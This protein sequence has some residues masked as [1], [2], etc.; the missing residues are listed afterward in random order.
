MKRIYRSIGFWAFLVILISIPFGC[1]S[2]QQEAGQEPQREES[3]EKKYSKYFF[4]DFEAPEIPPEVAKEMEETRQKS[5][6]TVEATRFINMNAT[7]LEGAPYMDFAWLWKGSSK[8]YVE[9]EHVHDFDEFIGFLGTRGPQDPHGLGGEIE[10]WLGGEKYQIT[11]SCLIYIPKGLKHCPIRFTR[12]DTPILFF[13]GAFELGEYKST[14][15][16]FTDAK[17][18]ERNYAK[19]FSYFVNPKKIPPKDD[20]E[21][22]KR[23][24]EEARQESGSTIESSGILSMNSI[25]GAPYIQFAWLYSGSEEKPTHPEHAHAWGEVFGY[26]G[27]VGQEDPYG[28]MGEVEFWVDGEKHVLTKSCLVWIPPNLPHCPVRFAQIDKP[29]LW[30]TLGIGMEG[31]EYSFSKPPADKIE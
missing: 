7:R 22:A 25:E 4:Y 6:S 21:E 12:I 5:E 3:S 28:P 17:A 20:S 23:K 26:I 16:E 29:I 9:S 15:T 13:S 11:K 18:A 2:A 30:F 10:F 24:L 27:Y 31:G 14:P 19:Y 8:D 1:N